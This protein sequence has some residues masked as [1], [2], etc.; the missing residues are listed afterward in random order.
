MEESNQRQ[1]LLKD[2]EPEIFGLVMQYAYTGTYRLASAPKWA[3]SPAWPGTELP[4]AADEE[5]L[6]LDPWK[7]MVDKFCKYCGNRLG[8]ANSCRPEQCAINT[9][10]PRRISHCSSCG[11]RQVHSYNT[12]VDLRYNP[13]SCCRNKLK[14]WNNIVCVTK[15]TTRDITRDK[16]ARYVKSM[17]SEA[18]H[19]IRSHLRL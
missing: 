5:A 11:C 3:G 10:D 2:V 12:G 15:D 14:H 4:D 19:D 7:H 18:S 13:H 16:V 1:A 9:A 6:R 8:V 17:R